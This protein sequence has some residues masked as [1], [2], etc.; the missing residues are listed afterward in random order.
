MEGSLVSVFKLVTCK[1]N[2]PASAG[3]VCLGQIRAL[4]AKSQELLSMYLKDM[5]IPG[6]LLLMTKVL[7]ENLI[8]LSTQLE[9]L[10]PGTVDF[11]TQNVPWYQ[12]RLTLR[13]AISS[14][15]TTNCSTQPWVSDK[16]TTQEGLTS[17][18][19]RANTDN[20]G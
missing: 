20:P 6:Y 10:N 13:N 19:K 1:Q 11:Y 3:L 18:P 17:R 12:L 14:S 7:V 5:S 15:S 2:T 4:A 8:Q 9:L 16:R